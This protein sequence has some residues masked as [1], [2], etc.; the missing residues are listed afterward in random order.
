MLAIE[1]ALHYPH[2]FS[3]L[4]LVS[5]SPS[6]SLLKEHFKEYK[7]GVDEK[8][9]YSSYLCRA[10]KWPKSLTS[11][12]ENLSKP[13]LNTLFGPSL[14]EIGGNLQGWERMKD[15]CHIAEPTLILSGEHYCQSIAIETQKHLPHS[16]F[17]IIRGASRTPFIEAPA[18]YQQALL[19]FLKEY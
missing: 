15:L 2:Q 18:Q 13:V 4:T 14:F 8:S 9:L 16:Y 1:Y 10:D 17:D 19:R 11:S 7:R 6:I 5:T 3:T 12:L